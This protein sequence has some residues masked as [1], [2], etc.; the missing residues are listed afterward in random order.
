[1]EAFYN[2]GSNTRADVLQAQ[3]RVG[4]TRLQ[5]ITERNNVEIA[6]AQLASTLN[7]GLNEEIDVSA[8]LETDRIDPVL[9]DEVKYMLEA[10][11]DLQA[12]RSR[13]KSAS[14][15]LTATESSRWPTLAAT[16]G[17]NWNNR[18][19][20]DNVNFFRNN[21]SW[22]IGVFANWDVFDGFQRKSSVLDAKAA[23]R[24][25]ELDLRQAKLN[26]ILEVKTLYLRLRE[27]EERIDVSQEQV[28]Q[29]AENL[30]LAGERYK[31][32]A[33]TQLESNEAQAQLTQA[34]SS[35]V[36]ARIDYLIAKAELARATGRPLKAK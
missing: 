2:I 28:D 5:L 15:N 19:F 24:V 27:A 21:Y 30:R 13:V 34:Q 3:V 22:N 8:S 31:V 14:A 17:Y 36:E 35:L 32:G 10:R 26:A 29:A 11:A 20:P 7:F 23:E 6:K 9:V 1:M 18:I 16:L 33:G 12:G 4:T 25:A